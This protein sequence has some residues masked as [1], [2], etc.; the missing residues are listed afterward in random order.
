MTLRMTG[1][2]LSL[3]DAVAS[4]DAGTVRISNAFEK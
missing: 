1:K 4:R 2:M 3:P